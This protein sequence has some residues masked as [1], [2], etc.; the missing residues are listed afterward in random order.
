MP[1]TLFERDNIHP[2]LKGTM[3]IVNCIR[4]KIALSER[5][6]SLRNFISKP[7]T[8]YSK[9]VSYAQ[10]VDTPEGGERCQKKSGNTQ[11]ENRPSRAVDDVR[12]AQNLVFR[13]SSTNVPNHSYQDAPDF[14][15]WWQAQ[16]YK[17][18]PPWISQVFH[19]PP[20]QQYY[21]QCMNKV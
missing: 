14:N 17:Y 15:T 4:K 19:P 3:A 16:A 21:A 1:G 12:S 5:K 13:N 20:M 8:P 9:H 11:P 6:Q 2:N 10:S 7:A 18:F